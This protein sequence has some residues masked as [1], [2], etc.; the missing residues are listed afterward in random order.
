MK[1]LRRILIL[2]GPGSGK[3]TLASKLSK[4]FDLPTVNLD[5][6]HYMKNWIPRSEKERDRIIL[7]KSKESEWIME[8]IYKTTLEKRANLADIIIILEYPTYK[9]LYRIIKRYICNLGKEKEELDECKERLSLGF[10]NYTL[11]FNSK[12]NEIYEILNKVN[13]ID[14]KL[15]ILKNGKYKI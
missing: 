9:L 13:N 4:I 11:K 1:E 6:I 7:K 10:I 3:T 8:G 15:F 2:G 12:K 14:T 5:N